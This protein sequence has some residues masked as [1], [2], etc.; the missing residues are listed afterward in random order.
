MAEQSG[1]CCIDGATVCL[2]T[3]VYRYLK[4]PPPHWD[5]PKIDLVAEL[6]QMR[7][8]LTK[9][10]YK[11]EYEFA[12]ELY[13]L[14]LRTQDGHFS[15]TPDILQPFNFQRDI[16]LTSVSVDGHSLPQVYVFRKYNNFLQSNTLF[17][18]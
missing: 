11:S 15:Y 6:A 8:K 4:N 1:V 7:E 13:D 12:L 9:K 2:L 14:P 5:S 17:R 18:M 16:L 10:A 3:A